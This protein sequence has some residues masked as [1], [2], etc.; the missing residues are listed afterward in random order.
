MLSVQSVG[1]QFA[2]KT[3]PREL[4]SAGCE[5][6]IVEGKKNIVAVLFD[7]PFGPDPVLTNC[8]PIPFAFKRS[9]RKTGKLHFQLLSVSDG[10]L[11]TAVL[12]VPGTVVPLAIC[13]SSVKLL[14][15]EAAVIGITV[16]EYL[17]T[18]LSDDGV[19]LMV[20]HVYA[21]LSVELIVPLS[22]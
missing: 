22:V 20:K 13:Q 17:T 14:I 12:H 21:T 10:K 16:D 9:T 5:G 15:G 11:P 8:P 19:G 6:R 1:L 7:Q 2:A 4:R 18:L 3:L